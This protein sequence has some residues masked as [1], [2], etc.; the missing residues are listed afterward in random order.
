MRIREKIIEGLLFLCSAITVLTTFGIL[1]VLLS[2]SI[3]FFSEVSLIDF[4]TDK[5]CTPLFA[6]NQF[7][8]MSLVSATLLPTS[9]A[10][11][12]ALP[13]GL[14]IAA[15]LHSSAPPPLPPKVK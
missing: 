2:E 15:S 3:K 5:D 9:I 4:L 8:I 1:F 12:V 13:P 6:D 11:L 10:I 7:G 14:T